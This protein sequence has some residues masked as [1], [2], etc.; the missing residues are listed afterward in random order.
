VGIPTFLRSRLAESLDGLDAEIVVLGVPTDEGSPYKP[1]SRF[2][3]RA[4]REHSLRFGAGGGG[5]H[6]PQTRETYLER[7][8]R[9]RRI[10]D[11]G[12]IP[13][14]PT[15]VGETFSCI[16]DT[17]EKVVSQGLLPV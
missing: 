7:E 9:E 11:G 10:V 8:M 15:N 5:F 16:T 3:P 17:V 1:G 12:D 4:I 14:L 6:D 13:I 2:A